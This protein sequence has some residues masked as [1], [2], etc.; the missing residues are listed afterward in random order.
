[1]GMVLACVLL[2]GCVSEEELMEK[3]AQA[4]QLMQ[5]GKYSEAASIFAELKELDPSNE[6]YNEYLVNAADL[7]MI[8][9]L[10]EDKIEDAVNVFKYYGVDLS[11]NEKDKVITLYKEAENQI[12]LKEFD[13]AS[14]NYNEILKVAGSIEQFQEKANMIKTEKEQEE[15]RIKIEKEKEAEQK[16][17]NELKERVVKLLKQKKYTEAYE[18]FQYQSFLTEHDM[19][20]K[21]LYDY[22]DLRK[23]YINNE[24]E[25]KYLSDWAFHDLAEV[26]LSYNGVF[27]KELL[28]F[29]LSIRTKEQ[30]LDIQAEAAGANAR[31]AEYTKKQ[32]PAIGMTKDE[33][34]GSRWGEPDDINT[35]INKYGT[36][37]QWVYNGQGYIYFE[38]GIVTSIQLD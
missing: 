5:L 24:D 19:E 37:E 6:K 23:S 4:G 20:L 7:G 30:W 26:P 29:K 18:A 34:R 14:N 21:M 10:K 8:N 11:P 32:E 33:I 31:L 28:D 36:S 13:K 3:E 2:V 17:I 22:A 12:E 15:K 1:M 35:T 27:A 9:Y 16:I 25:F 38:D